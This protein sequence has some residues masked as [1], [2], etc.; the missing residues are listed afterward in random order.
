MDGELNYFL[1]DRAKDC[2]TTPFVIRVLSRTV[3]FLSLLLY[4]LGVIGIGGTIY[5][6][7]LEAEAMAL[8]Y[9]SIHLNNQLESRYHLNLSHKSKKRPAW[10]Q[11]GLSVDLW[12][13]IPQQTSDWFDVREIFA[14]LNSKNLNLRIGRILPDWAKRDIDTMCGGP[15]QK[16]FP[17]F[18]IDPLTNITDGIV[19]ILGSYQRPIF[20]IELFFSPLFIPNRGGIRFEKTS[21]EHLSSV[22]RWLPP[23]F[24]EI[25]VGDAVIPIDYSLHL[26]SAKNVVLNQGGWLRISLQTE[27]IRFAALGAAY[28][29]P[30][31][32]LRHNAKLHIKDESLL[33]AMVH[34]YPE[35]IRE[36]MIGFQSGVNIIQSKIF[37]DI[38]FFYDGVYVDR[39]SAL[40]NMTGVQMK[41]NRRWLPEWTVAALFTKNLRDAAIPPSP[42]P[43]H[44]EQT[45]FSKIALRP[46]AASQFSLS[47]ETD[48]SMRQRQLRGEVALG[49]FTQ[50]KFGI[51]F[52]VISGE[53]QTY[54]GMFRANDRIWMKGSY[55]F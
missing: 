53:E 33:E 11:Y 8:A 48:L 26:P 17:K 12:G 27:R 7:T 49:P 38:D 14:G 55:V 3:F 6:Q 54:W 22:S 2:A 36:Q 41:T 30:E 21:D 45:L 19:G 29:N 52:D 35:F 28:L 9:S 37:W 1:L 31:P 32:T 46:S 25:K 5:S 18:V 40:K 16:M 44:P 51:G 42:L 20:Q 39:E 47:C 24:E 15:L 43:S 34:L 50:M 23:L 4:I 13:V 10:F